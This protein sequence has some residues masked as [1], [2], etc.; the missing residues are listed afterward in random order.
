[1]DEKLHFIQNDGKPALSM[2]MDGAE[3]IVSFSEEEC[4]TDVKKGV[5]RLI[6]Q[7][8]EDRVLQGSQKTE[9]A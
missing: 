1:M 4:K 2:K 9:S 6:M 8:Y 3:V 5:L 7:S